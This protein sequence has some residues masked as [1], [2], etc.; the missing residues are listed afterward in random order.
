M[1]LSVFDD[2][3]PPWCAVCEKPVDRISRRNEIATLELSFVVECHGEHEIA[4]LGREVL[5]LNPRA[6]SFGRAFTAKL[7]TAPQKALP[8]LP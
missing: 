8:E 1:K 3:A 7:L 6:I 4:T 2:I 5:E